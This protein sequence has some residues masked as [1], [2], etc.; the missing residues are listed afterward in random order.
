MNRFL[1]Y[2]SQERIFSILSATVLVLASVYNFPTWIVYILAV[3]I[4]FG[5]FSLGIL[6]SGLVLMSRFRPL[7]AVRFYVGVAG[8]GYERSRDLFAQF[9][10]NA[11]PIVSICAWISLSWYVTAI[12]VFCGWVGVKYVHYQAYYI[13]SNLSDEA[14]VKL[15]E[16]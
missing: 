4:W 6:F 16:E 2:F 9:L 7:A 10:D 5:L 11:P 1:D 13:A 12:A 15:F 3:V 8:R 14:L